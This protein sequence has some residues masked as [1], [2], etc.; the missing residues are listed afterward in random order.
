MYSFFENSLK[1]E[2]PANKKKVQII[3]C[4]TSRNLNEYLLSLKYRKNGKYDKIPN[5]LV[6][7][8]G[9]VINLL[10]SDNYS[11]Y[12]DNPDINHNSIII[13]LE[14][15]GWLEKVQLTSDYINW[16][17]D[18]YKGV[19]FERKWRDYFFWDPYTT[20]QMKSLVNLCLELCKKY[21][22]PIEC[23]THNTK[24]TNIE[25]FNGIVSKSNFDQIFTDVSPAFDFNKFT[26][27]LKNEQL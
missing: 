3:L 1:K 5:F 2:F 16:I 18:I 27:M 6:T 12:F 24:I 14:N 7:K 25:K 11:N 23:I 20:D 26:N 10:L 21:K 13:S 17:G 19:P 22:I 8:T 15:L 4:H 9:K